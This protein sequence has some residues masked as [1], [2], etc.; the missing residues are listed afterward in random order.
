MTWQY[1]SKVWRNRAKASVTDTAKQL[2]GDLQTKRELLSS[3][4]PIVFV[5][6]SLG[7]IIV[8]QARIA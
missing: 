5:A 4:G 6:H 7:G 3:S 2:L 1:E 8:K